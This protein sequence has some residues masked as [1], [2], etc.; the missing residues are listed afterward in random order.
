[1]AIRSIKEIKI[2]LNGFKSPQNIALIGATSE[3]GQAVLRHL[4]LEN[5]STLFL[6]A[7]NPSQAITSLHVFLPTT[8]TACEITFS[9]EELQSH[10]AI[11]DQL[12]V[13]GDL[14]LAIIAIGVL[15][16][17]PK[18]DEA[19]NALLVMQVNYLAS[20][21]LLLL[22][23]EKMKRQGH[24]QILIISSFAQTR[25]RI[26]NFSYGSSKAG[27]DFMA[28]GLSE[29]LQG[30]GVSIS[31]LRPGYVRTRMSALIPEAPFA[32]DA[33]AVG[34]I[35]AAL[36]KKEGALGYAP[37]ILA[38]VAIIFKALPSNIFRKISAR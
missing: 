5:L 31:I 10:R 28:R 17:D 29:K 15:G 21:H 16:N 2:M 34:K 24:G 22:I 20:A 9:A 30:S 38:L 33:T 36:L 3:I 25:P 12:F 26:D 13:Q 19:E 35:G 4:P 7:R 8:V 32:L 27:I 37:G 11:V 14:D 18:L 23:A 1:M 6:L